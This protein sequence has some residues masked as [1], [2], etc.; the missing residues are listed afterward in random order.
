MS[1]CCLLLTLFLY[2]SCSEGYRHPRKAPNHAPTASEYSY[3]TKYIAQKVSPSDP[4]AHTHTAPSHAHSA[5]VNKKK[6]Q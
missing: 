2:C 4:A 1:K 3:K 6:K 5:A